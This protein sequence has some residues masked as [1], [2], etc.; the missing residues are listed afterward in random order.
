MGWASKGVALVSFTNLSLSLKR[1]I[2]MTQSKEGG[3]GAGACVVVTS[4]SLR[5]RRAL[6]TDSHCWRRRM[7]PA[8]RHQD[9]S[10]M[11]THSPALSGRMASCS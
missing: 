10:H 11:V 9:H 8:A 1:W 5:P 2:K 6:C 4:G 7:W 3:V